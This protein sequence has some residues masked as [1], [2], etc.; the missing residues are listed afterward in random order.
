MKKRILFCGCGGMYNYFLGVANV[1]Q[2]NFELDNIEFSGVSAGNIP[3]VLLSLNMDI[4]KLFEEKNIPFLENINNYITKSLFNWNSCVRELLYDILPENVDVLLSNK[5][6][7]YIT[8]L[9]YLKSIKISNWDSKE[10]FID[11]IIGSSFIPLFD[12]KLYQK[13]NY[14]GKNIYCLDGGLSNYNIHNINNNDNL[15]KLTIDMWRKMETNWYYC[16]NDITWANKLYNWGK[17]DAL[18]NL[19]YFNNFLKKIE[20]R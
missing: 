15:L 20:K 18:K 19:D 7:S 13:L 16:Y 4:N 6:Q 14:N 9:P 8:S 2:N 3:A 12:T 5:Y 11:T 1:L 10:M 17:E